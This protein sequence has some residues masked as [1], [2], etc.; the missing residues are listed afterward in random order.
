MTNSLDA[1]FKA[2][3]DEIRYL[4]EHCDSLAKQVGNELILEKKLDI[5]SKVI[6][7]LENNL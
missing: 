5:Q 2:K 1:M 7:E 3:M 4:K 6:N